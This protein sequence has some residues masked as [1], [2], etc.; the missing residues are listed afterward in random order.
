MADKNY[1][2]WTKTLKNCPTGVL[3]YCF[4]DEAVRRYAK[5]VLAEEE[6]ILK[7]GCGFV[8]GPSWVE[9]AKYFLKETD[10]RWAE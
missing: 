9:T 5:D 4:T 2:F 3:G 10:E 1:K 8:D 6:K 7:E